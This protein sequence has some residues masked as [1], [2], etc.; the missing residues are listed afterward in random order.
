MR[1]LFTN[2][3]MEEKLDRIIEL[4][5]M[6]VNDGKVI[7]KVAKKTHWRQSMYDYLTSMNNPPSWVKK[8]LLE[9]GGQ[10]MKEKCGDMTVEEFYKSTKKDLRE[11]FKGVFGKA[12]VDEILNRISKDFD[13]KALSK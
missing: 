4:L 2:I 10:S 12:T 9:T 6:L 5:E 11:R 3:A 1:L 13:Y 8:D 7:D